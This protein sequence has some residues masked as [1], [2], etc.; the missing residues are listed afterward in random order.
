MSTVATGIKLYAPVRM[1]VYAAQFRKGR[2]AR[3]PG[4]FISAIAVKPGYLSEDEYNP[5]VLYF[6]VS[7]YRNHELKRVKIQAKRKGEEGWSPYA[8]SLFNSC[9]K[10]W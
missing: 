3:L 5:Y 8:Q 7:P 4:T 2:F 1:A 9:F 10:N 6:T